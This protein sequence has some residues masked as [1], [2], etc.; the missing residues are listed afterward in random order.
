MSEI[1]SSTIG[2]TPDALAAGINWHGVV[3]GVGI[4]AL[5]WIAWK[6]A[7]NLLGTN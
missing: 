3:V 7:K 6:G 1:A 5:A 2:E 4:A